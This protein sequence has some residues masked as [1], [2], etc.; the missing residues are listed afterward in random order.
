MGQQQLLLIVLGIIVVGVAILAGASAAE[1][2]FKQHDA[3][4]LIN[5]CL[6]I[7]QDAVNW[8]A[9]TDPFVGGSASYAGLA[10]GGFDQLFLGDETEGGRFKIETATADSL[11]IIAVSKRFPEVGVRVKVAG[12]EIVDTDVDY[13]GGITLN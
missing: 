8:K 11:V 6:H 9:K 5:R 4:A 3:D 12:E 13:N 1:I 2:S 10:S 7:A